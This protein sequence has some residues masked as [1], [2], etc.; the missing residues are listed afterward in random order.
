[1]SEVVVRK[2]GVEGKGV[3]AIKEFHK[4]EKVFLFSDKIIKI[5]HEPGCD[6]GICK[7]CINISKFGWLYPSRDSF[8][9][10][11]NHSC[12]PNCGIVNNY[13][14][15]M[16]DIAVGQEITID[17]STTTKDSKWEMK[18]L[19]G[20]PSCRK[21]IKSVQF[22]PASLFKR[23]FDFIPHFVRKNRNLN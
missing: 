23:Y 14:V 4:G 7:R 3:F 18:C 12:E 5:E 8:G 2:S 22:L 10:N 11:L 17:Y 6:C 16:K 15:A 13:I 19:C 9:W 1:M 21:V 20:K